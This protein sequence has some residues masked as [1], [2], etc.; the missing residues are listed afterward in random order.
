MGSVTFQGT[1]PLGAMGTNPMRNMFGI[2]AMAHG[3]VGPKAHGPP[4]A[5]G[6]DT[7]SRGSAGELVVPPTV[8]LV[9]PPQMA[10]I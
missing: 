9:Y 4:P 5:G 7:L 6:G 3:G 2:E 10:P 1:I 8:P